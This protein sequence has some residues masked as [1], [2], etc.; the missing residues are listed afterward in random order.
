[1]PSTLIHVGR[2]KAVV[3]LAGV[4]VLASVAV[5]VGWGVVHHGSNHGPCFHDTSLVS[6][7]RGSGFNTISIV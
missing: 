1:M 2:I 4:A 5:V 6:Y 3:V 7:N